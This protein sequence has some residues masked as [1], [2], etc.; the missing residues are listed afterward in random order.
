MVAQRTVFGWVLSGQVSGV[1]DHKGGCQLLCL[2]DIHESALRRLWSLEG[3]GV[4]DV[5]T[6]DVSDVM[7]TFESTVERSADGRYVVKLPWKE[8]AVDLL[9]DNRASAEKRLTGLG[10]K[11]ERDPDLRACYDG[12]LCEMEGAGVIT[13][14]PVEELVTQNPTFYLPHRPVV[15]ESSTSTKVRPVFDASARGPNGVS[16]NDCL[17][18]GPCLLPNLLEVLLR[19]RRW[20]FAV[21]ADITKAFLQVGLSVEDQDTHRFLWDCDGRVRVMK[22]QRVIFGVSSSPFLLNATIRHHLSLYPDSPAIREMRE[23]F[24]V[25]DLLS[26]ANSESEAS[27]LLSEAQ[28]VMRDAHMMLT[29]CRSNSPLLFDKAQGVFGESEHVK[30][31]GVI[32]NPTD[33][34]FAFQG[35]SLPDDIVPT[36]RV[37]LSF[38]ARMFDPLGFIS[39]FVMTLKSLFQE[40]WQLGLHWDDPLPDSCRETFARWLSGLAV[41]KELRV[42]RRYSPSAWRDGH[43]AELLAFSD[44]S[45]K[46][47]GATVY[48]RVPLEDGSFHVSLVMA[49][50][51]VAPVKKLSLPRLELLGCL[52]AARLVVFVR[53]A[54]RLSHSTPCLCWTDSMVALGWIRADPRKWKEFV[55][56]RVTE[57]QSL[58]DPERWQHCPGECNPADLTTRG[59]SAEELV[60]SELWL[61]GPS[62]LSHCHTP[63]VNQ[64]VLVQHD[65]SGVSVSSPGGDVCPRAGDVCP[66][67]GD[68]CSLGG[69][70]YRA[71]GDV[72]TPVCSPGGTVRTPVCSPGCAVCTPV[73]SPGGAV[74]SSGGAACSPGGA[75]RTPVCS[76]GWAVCSPGAAVCSPGATLCTPDGAVCSFD[77]KVSDPI[78][79]E[80]VEVE[81]FCLV[82]SQFEEVFPVERWGKMSKAVRVAGWVRRFI[83]NCRVPADRCSLPDLTTLELADARLDLLR[84]EQRK[85]FS[86]EWSALEKRQ[87]L[88]KGSRLIGLD[89]FIA[90]DRLLRV[91]GRLEFSDLMY[92]EKHPILL[93]KCHLAVL[94]ARE[95]HVLL[96]HAGVSTMMTSL[97]GAYWILGL[98]CIAKGVKRGCVSCLRHD[99]RPFNEEAAPLPGC[100]VTQSPPFTVTGVD[101]CGPLFSVDFPRKKFY[102]CLFTCAVT[103]AVHLE[104]T[105]ALSLPAFMLALRRFSARR[106]LP[107]IMYSDNAPTFRGADKQLQRVYSHLAPEWRFI[108]PHSPWWGGWWERL[109]RSVK[110]GLRKSLG[111]RCLSRDELETVLLEVECCVNSRPLTFVGDGLDSSPPIT[112]AHFLTGRGT[113]FSSRVVEDPACVNA[114]ALTERA[115]VCEKRLAR[116]WSVW[117][118]EYVRTLPP[119]VRRFRPQGKLSEG[120]MVMLQEDNVP[121]M[122]W[123]HGV[124]TRLI[125]GRDGKVRSAE[126]RTPSGLKTRPIQ[127]LFDLDPL[128]SEP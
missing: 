121:R 21:T 112:P 110:V 10:R 22:S 104:M 60:R 83:R 40:L 109:I 115:R 97:R 7:T 6:G 85:A 35:V 2:G 30:V 8:G 47:Y 56:N 38:I 120:S 29:K 96:K 14:V 84:Q 51:R 12:A 95:Q 3:V 37:V 92:E 24:Y 72:S 89:P 48:I 100:R 79:E 23:N 27:A 99:S 67:G 73:C 61:S 20:P 18:V 122:R 101:F 64:S 77:E 49:K 32:W 55:A 11:L 107:R 65:L 126:V 15:K 127:R 50:S 78:T 19:F 118:K 123:V 4:T 63:D 88:P 9:Q 124:V 80:M 108:V 46:G 25:D 82:T 94:L 116:F 44:A 62:W 81:S 76:P 117:Y 74:C 58:T 93:P 59:V 98:R 70:V 28:R 33:D 36:K 26:G 106:G 57:I 102:V 5:T 45:P 17:E 54:L 43:G 91:R 75:V 111:S 119:S 34:L 41:L 87:S 39:P 69:D 71:G 13:E 66:R 128:S 125:T 52:I 105:D 86:G 42:P 53:S 16:L 1:D 90:D 113:G 114:K 103:R 68:V 31:L